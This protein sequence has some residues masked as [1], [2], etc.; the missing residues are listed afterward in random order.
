MNKRNILFGISLCITILFVKCN[1]PKKGPIIS[2][3]RDTV[4]FS[5][6]RGQIIKASFTIKNLGDDTLHIKNINTDCG[7]TT[8]KFPE[9]L[10][11][12]LDSSLVMVN[13]DT[14]SDFGD[15]RKTIVIETNTTPVL[16]TLVLRGIIKE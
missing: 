9:K 2:L 15:T 11:L 14:K 5:A 7:C 10:I 6:S 8:V 3:D 4:S 13:Y 12:P 1:K 16:H